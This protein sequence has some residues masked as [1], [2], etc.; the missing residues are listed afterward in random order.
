MTTPSAPSR[1]RG[2]LLACLLALGCGACAGSHG[3]GGQHLSGPVVD[4]V[5]THPSGVFSV[6]APY[7]DAEDERSER[8]WHWLFH[9]EVDDGDGFVGVVF[10]P[11]MLDVSVFTVSVRPVVPERPS[12]WDAFEQ[13]CRKHNSLYR[14]GTARLHD[15][16]L[17]L[18]GQP[19]GFRVYAYRGHG[20]W[21]EADEADVRGHVV[22]YHQRRA[23]HDVF[24]MLDVP[25]SLEASRVPIAASSFIDEAWD[26]QRRFVRSFELHLLD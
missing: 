13:L 26:K 14:G 25:A 17:D 9:E 23:G 6:W 15:A 2:A 18:D 20:R 22:Y 3:W 24:F 10:G 4:G 19:T 11:A 5:Y 1:L 8:E 16:T 21:A 12:A 7:S